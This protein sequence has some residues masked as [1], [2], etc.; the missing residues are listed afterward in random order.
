MQDTERACAVSFIAELN[1]TEFESALTT[2]VLTLHFTCHWSYSFSVTMIDLAVDCCAG[3]SAVELAAVSR[4]ATATPTPHAPAT[5]LRVLFGGAS[6]HPSALSQSGLGEDAQP[7]NFESASPGPLACT[8]PRTVATP[9]AAA[10]AA[11]P[12]M[13]ATAPSALLTPLEACL[14]PSRL[15]LVSPP[16]VA[17]AAAATMVDKTGATRVN[18][19]RPSADETRQASGATARPAV[20]LPLDEDGDAAMCNDDADAGGE[21]ARLAQAAAVVAALRAAP[22]S[23]PA[24]HALSPAQLAHHAL[25]GEALE[26]AVLRA[27]TP[28]CAPLSRHAVAKALHAEGVRPSG[29]NSDERRATLRAA[30]DS[31]CSRGVLRRTANKAYERVGGASAVPDLRDEKLEAGGAAE[32][33]DGGAAGEEESGL[34]S[35]PLSAATATHLAERISAC[36]SLNAKQR[37]V[38]LFALRTVNTGASAW[39]HSPLNPHAWNG[40]SLINAWNKAHP[41]DEQLKGDFAQ[42]SL[43]AAVASRLFVSTLPLGVSSGYKLTFPNPCICDAGDAAAEQVA[44]VDG[45]DEAMEEDRAAKGEPALLSAPLSTGAAAAIAARIAAHSLLTPK[46]RRVL[47]FALRTA[48]TS[49]PLLSTPVNPHAWTAAALAAAWNRRHLADSVASKHASGVL[50]AAVLARLFLAVPIEGAPRRGQIFS[51]PDPRCGTA[52]A[53]GEEPRAED[54]EGAAA[55]S[56]EEEGTAAFEAPHTIS[57]DAPRHQ[58]LADAD[59]GTVVGE[60]EEAEEGATDAPPAQPFP[61]PAALAQRMQS[62]AFIT[63]KLRRIMLFA[64]RTPNCGFLHRSRYIV[65]TYPFSWTGMSL[66]EAWSAAHPL[67]KVCGVRGAKALRGGVTMG[68]FRTVPLPGGNQ[69]EKLTIPNLFGASVGDGG[70]HPGA[71][72]GDVMEGGLECSGKLP[73]PQPQPPPS[74]PTSAREAQLASLR[75]ASLRSRCA[76]FDCP[77]PPLPSTGGCQALEA[78]AAGVCCRAPA[79]AGAAA[80]TATVDHVRL[81]AHPSGR[82]QPSGCARGASQPRRTGDRSRARSRSRSRSR[83][84]SVSRSRSVSPSGRSPQRRRGRSPPQQRDDSPSVPLPRLA[85]TPPALPQPP[86]QAPARSFCYRTQDAS[87]AV[88][89]PFPLSAFC[90]WME[91]EGGSYRQT[92]LALRV[93][94]EGASEADLKHLLDFPDAA[95][96][97]SA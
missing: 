85:S 15:A 83:G 6:L 23:L 24:S 47:L 4:A 77:P 10:P 58:R 28:G 62:C 29:E 86:G 76:A 17:A 57:S 14:T 53:A 75:V 92:L 37:R 2:A 21:S 52:E 67:E 40:A 88:V 82:H 36:A 93:W 60:E 61:T 65:P 95:A 97:L 48:N 22:P 30:L 69:A 35:R 41:T 5:L 55:V 59:G 73:S 96:A 16:S 34:L 51:F 74:P 80:D 26:G 54:E 64:L 78:H 9:L 87:A 94:P 38:L 68:F 19:A 1:P 46:Q 70:A 33:N 89:G 56:E 71:P 42:V 66:A 45:R 63:D 90:G 27:L 50:R 11:R 31:L 91:A 39:G 72:F 44:A 32:E 18:A 20:T 12:F 8:S 3:G 13:A 81:T 84:R 43:K 79:P 49:K 25:S 7:P